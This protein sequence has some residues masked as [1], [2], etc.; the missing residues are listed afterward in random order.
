MLLVKHS[1]VASPIFDPCCLYTFLVVNPNWFLMTTYSTCFV[2]LQNHYTVWIFSMCSLGHRYELL[3]LHTPTMKKKEKTIYN[4][5]HLSRCKRMAHCEPIG[6]SCVENCTFQRLRII[7][8]VLQ[9]CRTLV[10]RHC[11]LNQ[12][13]RSI[14]EQ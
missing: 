14:D 8:F 12:Y 9:N 2:I 4:K 13:H 5:K 6:V 10:Y 7:Y 3:Q 11:S 1:V